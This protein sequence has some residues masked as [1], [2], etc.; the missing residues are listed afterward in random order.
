M[1]QLTN[2]Y[3]LPKFDSQEKF[4]LMNISQQEAHRHLYNM[5]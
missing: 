1:F 5:F 2:R 4:K 3:G